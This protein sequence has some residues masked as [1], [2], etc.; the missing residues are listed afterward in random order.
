MLFVGLVRTEEE[1]NRQ[2]N[3]GE[4]RKEKEEYTEM[5]EV[6]DKERNKEGQNKV[7]E[8]RTTSI[9]IGINLILL[10]R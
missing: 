6:T 4:R 1:E 10:W 2:G 8:Y 3:D 9:I 7:A 5:R